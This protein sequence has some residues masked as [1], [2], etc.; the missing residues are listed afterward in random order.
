MEPASSTRPPPW[1]WWATFA[2]TGPGFPVLP[3]ARADDGLLD[4]CVMP[5]TSMHELIPL[6]MAAAAGE[7]TRA[8]GVVYVKGRHITVDSPDP[9]PVQVDGEPAG[10]TPLRIDLLPRRVAFVVPAAM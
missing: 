1:R 2:S 3:H 5:C 4:V 8:E 7:H 9:V 6:V 10:T